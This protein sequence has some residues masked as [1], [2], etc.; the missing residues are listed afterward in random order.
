MRRGAWRDRVTDVVIAGPVDTQQLGLFADDLVMRLFA[1]GVTRTSIRGIAAPQTLIEVPSLNLIAN[2]VTMAEIAAATSD[3]AVATSTSAVPVTPKPWVPYG[4]R[5][6]SRSAR[7]SA[8]MPTMWSRS[9]RLPSPPV[10]TGSCS[11]TR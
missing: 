8:P 6:I 5:R 11:P 1:R 9:P 10:P 7:S 2:D 4:R 3:R